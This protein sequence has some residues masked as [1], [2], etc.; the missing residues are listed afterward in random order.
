MEKTVMVLASH[1]DDAELGMGGTLAALSASG[2]KVIVVDLTDGEPT[3]HGTPELRCAEAQKASTILKLSERIM[4]NIKNR[5]IADTVEN[6]QQVAGLIRR[7]KPE[8]LFTHYWEDAHPDHVAAAS[9]SDAARF[10]SK[11]VKGSLPYEPHFPRRIIYYFGIHL[12]PKVIP[13]FVFDI[14]AH[15]DTK[16]S[17]IDCY[18]SQFGVNPAN[19]YVRERIKGD[20]AFWGAQ[21]GVGY[22]EP[23]V[24]REQLAIKSAQSLFD[25]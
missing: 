19:H 13:S 23:F 7:Y 17:A 9:L 15:I 8:L 6:R 2:H 20:A 3:P 18:H 14:S 11:F 22:G 12:R 25:V 24:M 4:L 16:L 21:I 10:Y 5:E 1:P